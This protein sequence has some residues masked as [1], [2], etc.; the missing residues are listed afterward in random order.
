MHR[1]EFKAFINELD[2]NE[3]ATLIAEATYARREAERRAREWKSAREQAV[4]QLEQLQDY[5]ESAVEAPRWEAVGDEWDK[6]YPGFNDNFKQDVADYIAT[7]IVKHDATGAVNQHYDRV[8]HE[9]TKTHEGKHKA[10][11]QA[12]RE[13]GLAS[14]V[15]TLQTPDDSEKPEKPSAPDT[16]TKRNRS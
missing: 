1:D 6:S 2:E 11:A 4:S 7:R 14:K 10:V 16:R 13:L 15:A 5:K 8:F 3:E 12:L 9:S